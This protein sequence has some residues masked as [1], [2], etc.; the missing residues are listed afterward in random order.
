MDKLSRNVQH[1]IATF[2]PEVGEK[3]RRGNRFLGRERDIRD[4]QN[5]ACVAY[6][7]GLVTSLGKS[8]RYFEGEA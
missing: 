1:H 5:N 4:E 2:A 6:V 7:C 3:V 8:A